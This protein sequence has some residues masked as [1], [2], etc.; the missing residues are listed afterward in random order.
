MALSVAWGS[1]FLV[2]T[3][4]NKSQSSPK[5]YALKDGS[6]VAVWEDWSGTGGDASGSAIRGQLFSADG[7]KKSGE[8]L[9]N[10]M[11]TGG[12]YDP[13]V[14]VLN[15]GRFVVA[16]EDYGSGYVAARAYSANG[17]AIGNEFRVS[18]SGDDYKPSI[19]A[20]STGGF[21]V[22][23][24]DT[25]G[26]MR[27]QSFDANLQKSG[28]E[29]ELTIY[30][31]STIVG[32]QGQYVVFS[33]GGGKI[34]GQIRNNDG[35]A[36]AGSPEFVI[37]SGDTSSD[38]PVAAKL[39]DGRIIVIWNSYVDGVA[40]P[41]TYKIKGQILNANGT[42]SGG[43]LVLSAPGLTGSRAATVTALADGGFA[44][45]YFN[46]VEGRNS[47]DIHV[48]AFNGSGARVGVDNLL[49][50][51]YGASYL[52]L[53]ALADGRLTVT[54]NSTAHAVDD[55]GS[56][57]QSQIV[58]LRQKGMSLIG[59][60]SD[61]RYYGSAFNDII[62]GEAG[63]DM[64]FGREGSDTLT[65]GAGADI[66]VFDTAAKV[67]KAKHI[68]RIT[69]CNGR[70]DKI[71]LDDAIFKGLSK[72]SGSID[73]P[74]KID[75]K[76]F[77]KGSSAHD[78]DDRIIVKTSGEILYDADGTGKIAA[79]V[80]AKLDKKALKTVDANDFFVI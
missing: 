2:N 70:E 10:T 46:L 76:A 74:V 20:L 73:K 64:L 75:K 48:S 77:W 72:K 29:A 62:K 33:D 3:T 32:L 18:S 31:D 6:F 1:V 13:L 30:G 38:N 56:S 16:W 80:I 68:D 44:V 78:T 22:S 37:A 52:N 5:T 71:Y 54:W 58:D 12:Q 51:V 69:D 11:T 61:D 65:G 45:G 66:F 25:F 41:D 39:S 23:Y 15:D 4:I 36:P 21:A 59:T 43:E 55:F 28:S 60:A 42:K 34:T 27:V 53:T 17:T 24:L 19:A 63:K 14:T 47:T 57:I 26:D 8:F 50:R 7:S 49:E 9:I 79:V 40:S 35:I 67:G